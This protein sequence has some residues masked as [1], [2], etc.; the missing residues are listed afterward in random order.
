MKSHDVEIWNQASTAH[1]L[2]QH[3][4][5]EPKIYQI[6]PT[7]LTQ[8][9]GDQTEFC[10]MQII[11]GII[12]AL[13]KGYKVSSKPKKAFNIYVRFFIMNTFQYFTWASM[14]TLIAQKTTYCMG[15]EAYGLE[16][17]T[18]Q[19]IF[20]WLHMTIM[21]DDR[22]SLNKSFPFSPFP[23]KDVLKYKLFI[24][25]VDNGMY[26]AMSTYKESLMTLYKV[27]WSHGILF[28]AM[29]R[30]MIQSLFRFFFKKKLLNFCLWTITL[31]AT[32]FKKQMNK[33]MC[34]WKQMIG[35]EVA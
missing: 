1:H 15:V 23:T 10:K 14:K 18:L 6:V 3:K 27:S 33:V 9:P 2:F 17:L 11:K 26:V 4:R 32:F 13:P 12:W 19:S 30:T 7:S 20:A 28:K 22:K 25:Y 5:L 34:Y 29:V 8:Y 16:Y 35:R 21:I 24:R 31:A